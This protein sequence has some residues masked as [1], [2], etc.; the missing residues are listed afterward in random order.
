MNLTKNGVTIEVP[1]TTIVAMVLERLAGSAYPVD[2]K[3]I[4]VPRIATY[5]AGQGGIFTGIARGRDG[6]R[7]YAL[8]TA[9]KHLPRKNW[10]KVGEAVAQMEIDGHKD[11]TLPLL[12]EQALQFANLRDLFEKE[13]YWSCEPNAAISDYAWGQHFGSGDQSSYREDYQWPAAGVRRLV[14]SNLTI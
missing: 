14:F 11:F 10:K 6:Q 5:W 2:L 8:I 7:D 4:V 1:D 9:S 12:C 3:G 13:Y